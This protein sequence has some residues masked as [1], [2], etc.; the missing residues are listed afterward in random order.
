MQARKKNPARGRAEIT[1]VVVP[2]L[3]PAKLEQ[4]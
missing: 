4:R 1:C 3:N 2:K